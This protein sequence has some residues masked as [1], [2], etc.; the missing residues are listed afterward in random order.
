MSLDPDLQQQCND[1]GIT[2]WKEPVAPV[3][4]PRR[5]RDGRLLLVR[6]QA[7]AATPAVHAVLSTMLKLVLAVHFCNICWWHT[8]Y[9]FLQITRLAQGCKQVVLDLHRWLHH[10]G[11]GQTGKGSSQQL[12]CRQDFASEP[13]RQQFKEKCIHKV[14]SNC[15]D[16]ARCVV[17]PPNTPRITAAKDSAPMTQLAKPYPDLTCILIYNS[18]FPSLNMLH[19]L[20]VNTL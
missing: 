2:F 15:V 5:G 8:K 20:C 10:G 14:S 18:L 12:C 4:V 11:D 17:L 16:G 19:L 7:A 6:L 9:C 3:R 13:A 1:L